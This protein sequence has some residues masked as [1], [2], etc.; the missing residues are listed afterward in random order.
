[1][2]AAVA[3]LDSLETAYAASP[4]PVLRQRLALVYLCLSRYEDARAMLGDIAVADLNRDE[5]IMLLYAD[6]RLGRQDLARQLTHEL[7]AGRAFVP[8]RYTWALVAAT[9]VAARPEESSGVDDGAG[10]AVDRDL[11]DISKWMEEG[12]WDSK[13]R[14]DAYGREEPVPPSLT[15]LNLAAEAGDEAVRKEPQR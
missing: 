8:D 15:R 9:A 2:P 14:G 7:A 4:D 11:A 6:S 1:M 12:F 5:R 3:G 13:S 10:E